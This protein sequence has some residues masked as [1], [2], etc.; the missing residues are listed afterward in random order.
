MAD[1]YHHGD[2]R[3]TLL[4]RAADCIVSRGLGGVSLRSLAREAGVSHAAPA[5]HFGSRAGLLSALAAEG[6]ELLARQLRQAGDSG[7][8]I[9][10]GVAYV[11]FATEFPAHFE[12]MFRPD[13]L[14]EADP[15][16]LAA[17]QEAFSVLRSGVDDMAVQGRTAD[18][19]AAVVAG[20]SLV[21]GLAV[22]ASCGALDSARL[23]QMLP[24]ADLAEVT[25]RAAGMLFG[26]PGRRAR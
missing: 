18:A 11:R 4:Q 17:K 26:S 19:A 10:V 14:D 15:A 3:R 22:L 6:F 9:D 8:F 1:E 21:H 24:D 20:W 2:L 7:E 5:H 25:R 13:L 12:V 23:R 16:L